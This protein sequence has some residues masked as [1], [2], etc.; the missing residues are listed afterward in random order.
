MKR[1]IKNKEDFV[2]A[3][4]ENNNRKMFLAKDPESK[5]SYLLISS[6]FIYDMNSQ[7]IQCHILDLH[8]DVF[9][10]TTFALAIKLSNNESYIAFV[11]FKNQQNIDLLY[12]IISQDKI[13]LRIINDNDDYFISFNN[14]SKKDFL[15]LYNKVLSEVK[16]QTYTTDNYNNFINRIFN[17][18]TNEEL[19]EVW[20]NENT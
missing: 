4:Q 11:D 2:Q 5:I 12:N 19:L 6:N 20:K 13:I 1:T 10:I 14:P 17:S 16:N 9:N 7:C 8:D 15:D 18:C 3:L